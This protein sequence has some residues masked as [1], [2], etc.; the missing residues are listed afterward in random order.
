MPTPIAFARKPGVA[1][2]MDAADEMEDDADDAI[3]AVS[4]KSAAHAWDRGSRPMAAVIS[5]S[6][7][8]VIGQQG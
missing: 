4:P 3:A 7:K 2:S 5:G 6:G 8:R 1:D